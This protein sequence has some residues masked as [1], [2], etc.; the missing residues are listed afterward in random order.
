MTHTEL[1]PGFIKIVPDLQLNFGKYFPKLYISVSYP[2]PKPPNLT[3][4]SLVMNSLKVP[5]NKAPIEFVRNGG[6][7]AHRPAHL[8]TDSDHSSVVNSSYYGGGGGGVGGRQPFNS[9]KLV[10]GGNSIALQ[11]FIETYWADELARIDSLDT[12]TCKLW[13]KLCGS[14]IYNLQYRQGDQ[15]CLC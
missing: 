14:F 6:G 3:N 11:F 9:S 12:W 8:A 2:I 5:K 1:L 4:D 15:F 10:Q 13:E 7:M